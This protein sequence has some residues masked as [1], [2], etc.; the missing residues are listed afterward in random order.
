L[1]LLQT[2]SPK[3]AVRLANDSF[4]TEL[5]VTALVEY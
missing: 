2:T 1:E 3:A 4:G 5:A